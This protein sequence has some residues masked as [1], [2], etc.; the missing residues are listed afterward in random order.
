M[1]WYP[2]YAKEKIQ[3]AVE[4][5]WGRLFANW[6]AVPETADGKGYRI[7]GQPSAELTRKGIGHFTEG[8]RLMAMAVMESPEMEARKRRSQASSAGG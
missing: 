7:E 2:M 8:L 1:F 4:S 5:E 3:D 6:G